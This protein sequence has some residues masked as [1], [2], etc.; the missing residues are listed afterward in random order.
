[1][2]PCALYSVTGSNA[3]AADKLHGLVWL[4]SDFTVLVW[5]KHTSGTA[6]RLRTDPA[7]P[8]LGFSAPAPPPP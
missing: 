1:R 8:A 2:R 4:P 6:R 7:A 5:F 3:Q